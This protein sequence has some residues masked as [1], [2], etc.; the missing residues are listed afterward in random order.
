MKNNLKEYVALH[1]VKVLLKL[2]TKFCVYHS[3][4]A[5]VVLAKVIG[6]QEYSFETSE[7]CKHCLT[8]ID[9]G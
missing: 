7:P 8:I 9:P 5:F 2:K 3:V 4:F 6:T 1:K